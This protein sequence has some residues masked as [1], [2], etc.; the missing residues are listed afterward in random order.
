LHRRARSRQPPC[1]AQRDPRGGSGGQ[2]RRGRAHRRAR[3]PARR[4]RG[5]SVA[6]LYIH[7][8][9]CPYVCPY[10]DFAKW[11]HRRSS[12]QTY[13]RALEAEIA[14]APPLQA[15]TIFLGGGTPNTLEPEA[16]AALVG[17]CRERFA[18]PDGAEITSEA[19]PD[20]ALCL[21]FERY[22]AAGVNRLSFGVQSF[23]DAELS[24]LGRG[25]S[26]ADVADAFAAARRA[27]FTNLSLDLIFGVPGQTRATWRRS[28]EDALALEPQHISTYGLTVEAGT[29]YAAWHER[30]PGAFPTNDLEADL[31]GLAI[32]LLEAHGFEHYEISNFARPGFRSRHNA[33]YWAN[34]DYLGLG[35][36]AASYLGGRRSTHT[37]DLNAYVTAAAA[38]API[39][40]E[41]ERLEGAARAGE[42]AM[43]ALRTAEGVDVAGFAERYGI[44]FLHYYGPALAEMGSAGLL[45]VK[46]GN[47]RLTR[48]GRFLANEVCAAFVSLP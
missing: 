47:V 36:G 27:G 32:E 15:E 31:Y 28:L 21:G 2:R 7:L 12:A 38:G 24:T 9:F 39:P 43:L 40:G 26:G 20:A 1:G 23:V 17:L 18:V 16:V 10:C 5:A 30:E 25:H 14:A 22:R 8:P 13:L 29:P 19:N 34:G 44:D 33:N 37:R 48:Q 42:A 41:S 46:P 3:S 6:G 45:E 35:V 11:P 4:P